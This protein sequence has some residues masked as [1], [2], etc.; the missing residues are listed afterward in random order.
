VTH[1]IAI[2]KDKRALDQTQNPEEKEKIKR[3]IKKQEEE[4][5]ENDITMKV[6]AAMEESDINDL[7]TGVTGIGDI[8]KK[9][10]EKDKEF[11][12]EYAKWEKE[13]EEAIIQNNLATKTEKP[14]TDNTTNNNISKSIE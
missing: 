12:K 2:L 4:R 13:K 3:K 1:K 5:K 14:N 11:N 7:K 9:I 6:V 8:V 10:R